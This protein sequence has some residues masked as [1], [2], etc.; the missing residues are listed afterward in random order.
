[1]LERGGLA[2]LAEARA[3]IERWRIDYNHVKPHSAHGGLTPEAARL[4]P[5]A[6]RLR[7]LISSGRSA[8]PVGEADRLSTPWALTMIEGPEEGASSRPA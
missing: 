1:M 4:N 5:A 8:V 2:I 6:V 7:N 3:V